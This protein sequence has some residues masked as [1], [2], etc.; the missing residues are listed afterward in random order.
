MLRFQ[1]HPAPMMKKIA[2]RA[3]TCGIL[4]PC[5]TAMLV[6]KLVVYLTVIMNGMMDN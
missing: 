4:K 6:F 2:D 3:L 5:S 1:Y